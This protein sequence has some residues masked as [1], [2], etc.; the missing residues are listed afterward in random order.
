MIVPEIDS[1]LDKAEK[2]DPEALCYLGICL[3]I[4]F[5]I[6]ADPHVASLWFLFAADRGNADAQCYLGLYYYFGRGVGKD[7]NEALR[8][9]EQSATQGKD[10]A[11]HCLGMHN[12][13]ELKYDE[14]MVMDD[15]L[16][17]LELGQ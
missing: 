10:L 2:G 13:G 7:I 4:G 16:G 5:G 11:M 17:L 3:D 15:Y 6:P 9:L 1:A 12:A 14:D 8:L